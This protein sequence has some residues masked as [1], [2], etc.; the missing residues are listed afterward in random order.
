MKTRIIE[1]IERLKKDTR[2]LILVHNYQ[3]SEIQDIADYVGDSLELAKISK[4]IPCDV[5]VFCGVHFMA[6][7][8]KIM[9]P[10]KKVI[11]DIHIS[12]I[13]TWDIYQISYL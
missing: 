3:L 4:N 7:T 13:I 2:A 10:H 6:E 1:K 12:R 9:N 8:A 11:I 5:I